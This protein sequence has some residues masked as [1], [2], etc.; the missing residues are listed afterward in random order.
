[1]ACQDFEPNIETNTVIITNSIDK[2]NIIVA[3]NFEVQTN[4][5]IATNTLV[6]TNTFLITNTNTLVQT[7]I[8]IATNTLVQTNTFLITNMI[9]ITNGTG[10]FNTLH[11][12]GNN[13]PWG[14]WSDGTTMWVIDNSD[15]KI[16]AY[17]LINKTRNTNKEIYSSD[18]RIS[19]FP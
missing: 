9:F 4:I 17:N 2:T 6:Q 16:Y 7:N 19:Y 13:S 18:G 1:M 5:V 11:L 12:A 14:V 8:V 3:T 15:D 10:D